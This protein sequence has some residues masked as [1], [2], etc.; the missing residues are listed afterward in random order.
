MG[1]PVGELLTPEEQLER[2]EESEELL[3]DK[4]DE[5]KVVKVAAAAFVSCCDI[6]V[7]FEFDAWTIL[8]LL[9]VSAFWS[10]SEVLLILFSLLL[11][12]VS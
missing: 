8:S 4:A 3:K 5:A 11:L 12:A 2:A 9:F 6:A 10:L 7:A 1:D